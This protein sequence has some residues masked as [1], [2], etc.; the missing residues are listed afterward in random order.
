MPRGGEVIFTRL[1]HEEVVFDQFGGEKA[2]KIPVFA[3]KRGREVV[4]SAILAHRK[5]REEE[6]RADKG[7]GAA[8]LPGL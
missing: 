5:G 7:G 4:K 2:R 6:I 1:G 8:G 3:Q